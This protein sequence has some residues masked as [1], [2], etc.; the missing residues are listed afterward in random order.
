MVAL[1][2]VLHALQCATGSDGPRSVAAS[3]TTMA[4]VL[5]HTGDTAV[6]VVDA[7]AMPAAVL[8]HGH[9][10]PMDGTDIAVTACLIMMVAIGV[11]VLGTLWRRL[12]RGAANRKQA[13]WLRGRFVD[14]AALTLLC[15]LRT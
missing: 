1:L 7:T 6:A 5:A 15:V 3:P 8:V 10:G 2:V 4:Q 9:H 12:V 13:G 11:I 14:G